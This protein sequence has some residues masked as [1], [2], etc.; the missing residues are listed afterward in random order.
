MGYV[1]PQYHF[2]FDDLSETVICTGN[3]ALLDNICNH[4]FDS[5]HD[6]YMYDDE[7][8]SDDPLIYHLPHFDEVCLSEPKSL[9]CEHEEC[10]SITEDCKLIMWIDKTP[11]KTPV[12]L[13]NSIEQSDSD[14]LF[15]REE[16]VMLYPRKMMSELCQLMLWSEHPKN[17]YVELDD[18]PV[19]QLLIPTTQMN[20]I[21]NI[22][23]K[24]STFGKTSMIVST[25]LT[26][27]PV[28]LDSN[29]FQSVTP[30]SS[31]NYFRLNN[32]IIFGMRLV[33][34]FLTPCL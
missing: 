3:D 27:S 15:Q 21:L 22:Y 13:P 9:C 19:L 10:H 4:L 26:K 12:P 34:L 28:P 30:D 7:F 5:D 24:A 8:T 16:M 25:E 23:T 1:S 6:F 20:L 32:S 14:G 17:F 29:R 33:I 2:I 31:I 11:D 18:T